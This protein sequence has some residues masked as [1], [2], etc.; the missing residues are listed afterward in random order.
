M[1]KIGALLIITFGVV[2]T[3]LLLL[4]F[5]PT[6][7]SIISTAN[8]TSSVGSGHYW[9]AQAFLLGIPWFV[10]FIPVIIG[11]IAVVMVLKR[12]IRPS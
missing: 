12:R 1:N 7:N 5:Q 4:V 8:T 10:S 2:V 3:Y 9:G 11:L 6:F